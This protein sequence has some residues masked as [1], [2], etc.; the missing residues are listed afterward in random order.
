MISHSRTARI[1]FA[2]HKLRVQFARIDFGLWDIIAGQ[3]YGHHYGLEWVK[4]YGYY[5]ILFGVLVLF[6]ILLW[7]RTKECGL[8]IRGTKSNILPTPTRSKF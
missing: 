8:T 5:G 6:G 7:D 3:N 1:D 2:L 4:S